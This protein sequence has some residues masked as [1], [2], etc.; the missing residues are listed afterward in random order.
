[1]IRARELVKHFRVHKRPPGFA[2]ALRSLVRRRYETVKAVDGVTFSIERGERVG[3]LGPNGAGKTT[4]LKVLAGLLHPTSGEVEV[5]GFV[6]FRRQTELLERITLVMGQKSQLI[7]DLPPSETYALNRAVFDVPDA[8]FRQTLDELTE[9]LELAPLLDKPTRQLS[10]GERM[11]CELAAALLHR[12]TTLFLDEPTI[13][14]DVAM[15]L[16]IRDFVRSYNQ[17]HEATVLLTSHYMDDVVALCPRIIVIDHGVLIHDGDLKGLVKTMDPDKRV[18]FTIVDP[19]AGDALAKLG[20]VL[21]RDGHR[22]TLRVPE[23]ELPGVVGHLLGPLH[24]A[25]LAIE[26]PP[27]EE[28]LRVMFGKAREG[29]AN[30]AAAVD[31]TPPPGKRAE[32]D[33]A[34]EEAGT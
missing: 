24:V 33:R 3:F 34:E 25:D 6:P 9:L 15:Q 26:D 4:T 8:Q 29:E 23:R 18:S 14:L 27:L 7:W 20:T 12:P 31:A 21:A 11:K 2:S 32:A 30:G 19:I 10:L 16:A 17:R 22:L 13:G 28:I 5:D 1:M